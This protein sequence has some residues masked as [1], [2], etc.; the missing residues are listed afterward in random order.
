VT[1]AGQEP[2]GEA[3]AGGPTGGA[4]AERMVGEQTV[5]E[6]AAAEEK[7]RQICL[8]LLT[9]APR[10]R[11]QLAGALSRRGV[12]QPV[13]DSVLARFTEA[14]LIDDATFARAWVE[15]RHHSRGLA[16]RALA[17]ELTQR[18]VSP[19]E[20]AAAVGE[21]RPDQEV[22]T[23]RALV[24]RT[25]AG[26]RGRPLPVRIRRLMSLLARRGY[27]RGLSYRLV[28]EALEQEGLGPAV[29]EAA[30]V[31]GTAALDELLDEVADQ[32]DDPDD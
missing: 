10:T 2:A 3:A 29:V 5:G 22:A 20:T 18:G 32:Q 28:R 21:L 25:L 19:D 12:P 7:A 9:A 24:A 23:A 15:S 11:A 17:A 14:G 30:G 6:G 4:V 8:R 26:T 31:E 16:R 1:P 27:P 13:A